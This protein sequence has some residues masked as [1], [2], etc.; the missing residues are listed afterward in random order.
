MH[1]VL[2]SG[3]AVLGLRD[4]HGQAGSSEIVTTVHSNPKG[5]APKSDSIMPPMSK[6]RTSAYS[7]GF[8]V[9]KR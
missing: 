6:L 8:S 5:I 3:Y 4:G 9:M 7:P 1:Q 2:G